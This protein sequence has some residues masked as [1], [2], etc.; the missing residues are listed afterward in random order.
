MNVIIT[1]TSRGI[2]L[3]LTT[4]SLG[5]GHNVL[6]IAREPE[7]SPELKELDEREEDLTVLKLDLKEKNFAEIVLT[8]IQDW[9]SV[10]VLINNAGIMS[11]D[12]LES[13]QVNSVVPF[14]LTRALF[15][16][17]KKSRSP[18]AVHISSQ[19]GSLQDVSGGYY[20]YRS[21]KA[22]LNMLTKCMAA[23][24]PWLTTVV[25]HPGWVRTRMGG[26]SAPVT[27]KKSAEGLWKVIH[28]LT[29]KDSGK[30]FDYQGHELEM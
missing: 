10:D 13:F 12:F 15:P 17:L 26:E 29:L 16:Y 30:F 19:M 23:D 18:K 24:E 7:N 25:M 3:E 9:N 11:E 22:A 6:A 27:P 4:Q 14:L 5:Q 20:A 8:T 2:G 28:E 21:S 1:G